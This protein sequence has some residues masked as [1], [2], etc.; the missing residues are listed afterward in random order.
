MAIDA[1]VKFGEGD[2][3][4][5]DPDGE[6]LPEIEGDSDDS[7]H[8]WWCELRNCGFDMVAPERGAAGEDGSKE[9]EPPLFF[10]PVTLRKRVDWASTQ[11]FMKCCQQAMALK[12]SKEEQEKGWIGQ[13]TVEVCRPASG[14]KIPFVTVKYQKVRIIHFR[15]DMSEP[16]PAEEIT[17]EFDSLVFEYLRTDP[18]TGERIGGATSKTSQLKNHSQDTASGQAGAGGAGGAGA[19]AGG[20]A[21]AA[22]AGAAAAAAGG[23]S[24]AGASGGNGSPAGVPSAT[25]AAVN[26]NF[27]GLWQGTGFGILPD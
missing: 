9:K 24:A 13:V 3:D 11:L 22:T 2:A 4:P 19:G 16:E 21:A 7:E 17:F 18:N 1:Y 10:K 20:A 12:Q 23:G 5:N 15:I 8:F 26:M 25:E 14:E 27:P 6:C